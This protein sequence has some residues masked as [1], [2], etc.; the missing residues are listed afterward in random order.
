MYKKSM[1]ARPKPKRLP[2]PV[3]RSMN[4]TDAA[5]DRLR[6]L[7]DRY[8]LGNNYLLVV[9]L[10][11]LDDYSDPGRLNQVFEDFIAEYGAPETGSRRTGERRMAEYKLHCF[12]QS[13]NAYKV[14]L[15]LELAGADWE[16]VWVD[17]FK[18]GTR[19]P[20]FAGKEHHGRGSGAGA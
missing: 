15:A 11:R 13:G 1:T 7:N 3:R 5:Y 18:G 20:E 12:A 9:L 10:E 2:L 17:F 6:G 19:S 4:L 8:G 16:P 14:A